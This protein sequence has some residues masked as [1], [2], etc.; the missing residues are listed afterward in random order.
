VTALADLL[1]D[2]ARWDPEYGG[3][4][5]SHLPMA[6]IALHRLGADDRRLR[7]FAAR[8]VRRLVPAPPHA[9]WPAGDP[10]QGR[11]GERGAWPAYRSLFREWIAHEG[12]AAMLEQVLPALMP[13]CGAAAFHGMIRTAY[14]V[15]AGHLAELADGLA[16]WSCRFLPLGAIDDD[17]PAASGSPEPL[18]LLQRLHAGTSRKRLIFE[19]MHDAALD[20]SF[21]AVVAS[22]EVGDETPARLAH[23]AALAYA[24]SGDFTALH[25]VTSC[26][27]MRVLSRF[28]DDGATAWRWYW[29][30]FVAGV[31]AAGLRHAPPCP[32][33]PWQQIVET[34][35]RSDDDH[36]IKLVDSCR[37][38]E[39]AYGGGD[40][41]RAASRAL[42]RGE[43]ADR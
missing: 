7:E 21:R 12:A 22:L 24:D 39:R 23:L 9:P 8:S 17:T 27:A 35:Q 16:Y 31:V 30:A 3:G 19:R 41:Q 33:L 32:L 38:E 2:A 1:H 36:V 29:Q 20:P 6:L 28:V 10:W 18:R 43:P 11:F 34:A 25:L 26:H 5:S 37:E 4:L 13:G 15:Q 42:A 40:W 14:A